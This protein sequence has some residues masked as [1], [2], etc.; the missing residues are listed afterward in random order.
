MSLL[1]RPQVEP[2]QLPTLSLVTGIALRRALAPYVPD[3]QVKWP[4]D[5]VCEQG[6]LA[7]ISLEKHEDA[8]CVGIGVNV[9]PPA[10]ALDVPGKNTPVYVADRAPAFQNSDCANDAARAAALPEI[11]NAAL[12][13]FSAAYAEWLVAGF[14]AFAHEFNTYSFLANRTVSIADNRGTVVCR[15][16]VEAIGEDGCL[17]VCDNE[18]TLRTIASGEAHLL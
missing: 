10:E 3:A 16:T 14:A 15:G 7:G 9:F 8:V 2:A 12:A 4:N 17:L 1:L 6:K 5:V 13:E 11:R 18:S